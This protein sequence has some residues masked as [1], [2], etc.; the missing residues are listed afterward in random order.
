MSDCS[1]VLSAAGYLTSTDRRFGRGTVRP[2]TDRRFGAIP[3]S[4]SVASGNRGDGNSHRFILFYR[5]SLHTSD[6]A[7]VYC[8][9]KSQVI[10]SSG[11]SVLLGLGH[12][13]LIYIQVLV[14]CVAQTSLF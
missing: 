5:E 13:S 11:D 1:C 12:K 9:E 7:D 4:D 14:H 2:Q 8:R 6:Q 3:R 10:V